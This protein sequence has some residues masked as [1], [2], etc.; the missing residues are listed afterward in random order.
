VTLQAQ[1]GLAW[2]GTSDPTCSF[3][4]TLPAGLHDLTAQAAGRFQS[5]VTN[6][7]I[8]SGAITTQD[9]ALDPLLRIYL[10]LLIVPP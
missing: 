7:S 3:T 1:P 4:F 8:I 6:V 5:T 9:L 2:P 10:P